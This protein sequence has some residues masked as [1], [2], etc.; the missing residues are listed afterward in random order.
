M[1][2]EEDIS[3]I[4]EVE[5]DEPDTH[6]LYPKTRDAHARLLGW[7]LDAFTAADSARQP[8]YDRWVRYY[9]LYRSYIKRKKGDWRSSVFVPYTFST[10]E[11]ITPKLVANLPDLTVKPREAQDVPGAEAMENLLEWA[12]E[13]TNLELEL[14]KIYK[15]SL[16]YGTGL[17]KTF[18]TRK[19]R[20]VRQAAPAMPM[21]PSA[22][23]VLNPDTGM[24][25]MDADGAPLMD[26][27]MATPGV[28][29]AL[30]EMPIYE[31]PDAEWVDIFN[32][33]PA[34]EAT[35]IEDARYTIQRVYR[36]AAYVRRKVEDGIYRLPSGMD[37]DS[38]VQ[39][40]PEEPIQ[41][42]AAEVEEDRGSSDSLR[43]PIEIWEIHT[44]EGRIITVGNRRAILRVVETP[45]DHAEKPYFRIPDYLQEGEFWGVGEIEAIEGLQDLENAIVN[46]RIDNVRLTM[47]QM[48]VVLPENLEDMRDLRTRPGG[49]IRALGDRDVR[50]VV[51][52]L[53]TGD[54]TSSAFAEAEQVERLI[55]RV[56]GV[57]AYQTG[58]DSASLNDT[59]TGI[60]SIQ[61]AGNTKFAMK[62]RTAEMTGLRALC[63]QWGSLL[64]QFTTEEISIRVLG[65]DGAYQWNTVAPDA[66]LGNFDYDVEPN[67]SVQTEEVRRE[68]ALTLL[69]TIAGIAPQAVPELLKDVLKTFGK[70][71][72]ESYLGQQ[73]IEQ[74]AYLAQ[75]Q[76][77]AAMGAPAQGIPPEQQ[78]G[79]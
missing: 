59:A 10:I 36:D 11:T 38:L 66:I 73:A 48:F 1:M 50:E 55:E 52:A 7:C 28:G 2:T 58:Q 63:R 70:K 56:S 64:Q 57:S 39:A 34:P 69:Q 31:G 65:P 75:M 32:F 74:A 18:H 51:T 35:S 23:P 41:D 21:M 77:M 46:Q 14:V 71:N 4:L 62:N 5:Q 79:P 78:G 60:R 61:E 43:Q 54:V 37:V 29:R 12:S 17:G 25:M 27:G 24:P 15:Q 49:V 33:W 20:K 8:L 68:Q 40:D 67:S 13:S 6:R 3:P 72:L 26:G 30:V 76:Q 47:D 9:K 53:D 22:Q 45:Y 42:R 16:K 19:T 44:I